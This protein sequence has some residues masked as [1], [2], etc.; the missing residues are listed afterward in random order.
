MLVPVGFL[1]PFQAM[2]NRP[3]DFVCRADLCS[4]VK[5]EKKNGLYVFTYAGDGSADPERVH[6]RSEQATVVIDNI[7]RKN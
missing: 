1:T 4:K 3:Q 6:L 2:V 5:A 7:G